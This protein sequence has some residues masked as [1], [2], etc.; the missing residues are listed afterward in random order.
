[1]VGLDRGDRV[2]RVDRLSILLGPLLG[3]L[4]FIPIGVPLSK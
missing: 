2:D 4:V 3:G 1:M